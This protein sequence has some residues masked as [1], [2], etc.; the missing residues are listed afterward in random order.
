MQ[1]TE[2]VQRQT[3]SP[4]SLAPQQGSADV[5]SKRPESKRCS[6]WSVTLPTSAVVTGAGQ[7]AWAAARTRPAGAGFG[8]RLL[9]DP[10]TLV[11]V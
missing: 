3:L 7:A 9:Q 1:R 6:L 4:G 11:G 10:L 5:F 8:Q 2:P